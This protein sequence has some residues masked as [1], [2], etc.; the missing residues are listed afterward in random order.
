MYNDTTYRRQPSLTDAL[1]VQKRIIGALILRDMKTRF[2]R[3]HVGY[4]IAI[5]WPLAHMLGIMG[6]QFVTAR[7]TPIGTDLAVF[8]G[9]GLLPYILCLYP[10]RMMTL[11]IV[12]NRPLLLFSIVKTMDMIIAR[13]IL[14]ILTACVVAMIFLFVLYAADVDFQP[15]D[16]AEAVFAV[17]AAIFLGI[18]IGT[19]NAVMYMLFRQVWMIIFILI[20]IVMYITSGAFILSSNLSVAV[21]DVLWFNPLFQMVEWLRSAYYDGY[22]AASLSKSYTLG[23]SLVCLF[24]GILGEKLFRGRFYN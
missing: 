22:G 13:A 9:T 19:F 2:G 15:I 12:T 4:L 21:R 5:A 8:A 18:S 1:V 17:L 14:E 11:A 24:F 10:A 16:T 7:V 6:A 23:F 3:S 20:M